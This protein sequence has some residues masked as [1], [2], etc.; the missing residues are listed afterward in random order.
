MREP[1]NTYRVAMAVNRPVA[2]WGRLE[3]EG[4][5]TLREAVSRRLTAGAR[6]HQADVPAGDG[7]ALAWLHQHGEVVSSE[8]D[9]E[10]VHVTVRITDAEWDRFSAR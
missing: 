7:A 3:A 8:P 4:V 2:W 10:T 1:T 5:E 6:L 9:G